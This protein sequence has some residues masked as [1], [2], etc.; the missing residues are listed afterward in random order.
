LDHN[1]K[2]NTLE[3]FSPLD[4]IRIFTQKNLEKASKQILQ[5]RRTNNVT[6]SATLVCQASYLLLLVQEQ[7]EMHQI[8]EKKSSF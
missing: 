2:K 5:L 1:G 6:F 4:G 3:F 8:E 7:I